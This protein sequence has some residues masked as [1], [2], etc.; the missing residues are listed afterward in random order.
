MDNLPIVAWILI[1][2]IVIGVT[3]AIASAPPLIA[4]VISG[5][6]MKGISWR[7][8]LLV[9]ALVAIPSTIAT[10]AIIVVVA[11]HPA[12]DPG[13]PYGADNALLLISAT[14]T[15]GMCWWKHRRNLNN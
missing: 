12:L 1:Y 9:G 4:G 2:V 11:L 3:V 7:F 6:L 10:M 5:C 15:V 13:H 8:G 14:V